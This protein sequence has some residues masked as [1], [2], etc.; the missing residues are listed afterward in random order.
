MYQAP[1]TLRWE[2]TEPQPSI[3]VINGDITAMVDKDGKIVGDGRVFKQIG[4][5]IISMI[6]GNII[7]Q[8]DKFTSEYYELE[9]AQM[10]IVMTPVHKRLKS[11]FHKIELNLDM[12]TM[13]ANEITLDEKT[14]NK[15]VITLLNKVLNPALQSGKFEIHDTER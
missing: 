3:L 7:V 12:K 2:C 13:F 4:D 9:N 6:N 1:S 8:K 11:L 14:G 15:T 10:R 5:I